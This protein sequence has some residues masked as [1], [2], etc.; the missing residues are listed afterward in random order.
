MRSTQIAGP[1][2]DSHAKIV[3]KEGTLCLRCNLQRADQQAFQ[4][5][6]LS[7]CNSTKTNLCLDLSRSNYLNSLLIGILVDA[8]TEMKSRNKIVS[9]LVS[10]EIGRFLHMAHLYH[11]FRYDIVEPPVEH[12]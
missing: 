8:V 10:P 3:M 4:E 9:V 6:C 2:F 7:L 1:V 5:A 11:L 12:V